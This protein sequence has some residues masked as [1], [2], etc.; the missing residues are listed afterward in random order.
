MSDTRDHKVSSRAGWAATLGA[1]DPVLEPCQIAWHGISRIRD[2]SGA[3]SIA[4]NSPATEPLG[5]DG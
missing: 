5:S 4:A 2:L 3:Q 1:F